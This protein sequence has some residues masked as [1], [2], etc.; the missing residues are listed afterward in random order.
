MV[1]SH[2]GEYD[3][4]IADFTRAIHVDSLNTEAFFQRGQACWHVD[5]FREAAH[6]LLK[7]AQGNPD[8]PKRLF[9]I[10]FLLGD[11]YRQLGAYDRAIFNLGIALR[12]NPADANTFFS[13]G[14]AYWDMNDPD[15]AIADFS[16]AIRL[17]PGL[18]PTVPFTAM[19][20]LPET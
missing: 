16:E 10:Y 6:D 15:R 20:F 1:Y 4:A 12:N 7:A 5:R 14:R 19:P 9:R 13:R 17:D 2:G 8:D 3:Q 18:R 11:S